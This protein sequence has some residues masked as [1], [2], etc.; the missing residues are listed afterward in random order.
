MLKKLW[1]WIWGEPDPNQ[2]E[3]M[4]KVMVESQQDTQKMLFS[5]V[6]AMG[7]ASSKQAQ[8]LEQYLKLFSSPGEPQ[9]WQRDE[10][11]ENLAELAKMN[12]PSNW[13]D[14]SDRDQADWVL[15]HLGEL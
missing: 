2:L 12:Y 1:R 11:A 9:T 5:A 13:K 14:L 7:D 4:F 8:V 6:S 15:K 10:E 3:A